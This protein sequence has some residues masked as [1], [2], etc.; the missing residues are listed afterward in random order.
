MHSFLNPRTQPFR[1]QFLVALVKFSVISEAL[2][3]SLLS[4][5]EV[6][7]INTIAAD[8]TEANLD[9]EVNSINCF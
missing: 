2:V 1:D 8:A 3:S 7:H 6:L 4:G 5:N 9:T